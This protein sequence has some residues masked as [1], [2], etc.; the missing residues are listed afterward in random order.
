MTIASE[1]LRHS[2]NNNISPV[3]KYTIV[4]FRP[5]GVPYDQAKPYKIFDEN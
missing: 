1:V 2:H 5:Q 3:Q 4:N